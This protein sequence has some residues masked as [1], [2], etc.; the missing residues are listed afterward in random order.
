MLSISM[1]DNVI[2]YKKSKETLKKSKS[3]ISFYKF[4]SRPEIS[5]KITKKKKTLKRDLLN[6]L[7]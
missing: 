6:F 2:S 7:L 1:A 3:L 5:P 4:G